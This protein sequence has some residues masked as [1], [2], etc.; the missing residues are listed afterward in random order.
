[1]AEIRHLIV[2]AASPEKVFGALTEQAGLGG[3]WT[4]AVKATAVLGSI[5]EFD[6][7]DRYHN[8]MRV[9]RLEANRLVGWEC[10]VGDPEWVGTTFTFQLEPQGNGTL[11]RFSHDAWREMTDFF[12]S[13]NTNWG[14]YMRSLKA[15][16][17]SGRGQPF[18][19]PGI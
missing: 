8:E 19:E 3:W 4:T 6:F 1:M 2:I 9:T 5:A 11:V 12:A 13:C 14:F 16:C 7:G 17:E 15:Y 18:G 10:L